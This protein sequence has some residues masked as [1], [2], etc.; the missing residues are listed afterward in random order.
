MK[1]LPLSARAYIAL[2]I[3]AGIFFTALNYSI[4]P[5]H[6]TYEL[7]FFLALTAVAGI[8]K[9]SLPFFGTLSIAYIFVFTT[10]LV[11]GVTESILASIVSS[12]MASLFN[13]R[14]RNP[15]YR[16]L[17]NI[18]AT[19]LTSAGA[20]NIFIIMR[21]TPGTISIPRDLI[22]VFSY[23]FAFY[24]IN[25]FLVSAAISLSGSG[26]IITIWR[27]NYLWTAINYFIAGSSIALLL[28]H[29]MLS[30]NVYLFML[31]LPIIYISYY[32]FKIYL[33]KLEKDKKHSKELADLYLSIIEALAFAIDAKDQTTERH[34]RRVQNLALGIA[35]EMKMEKNEFEALKA[36][37]LLHDIGKIAVPEYIL[38]KPGKLTPEEFKSM[39]AHSDIGA[40]IL[41]TVKFPYPLGPIVRHHHE[42]YDGSGYPEGLKETEIPLGA[43][44]LAIVD[45]YDAL[46]TDRPYRKA[47]SR[48]E[49]VQYMER[50]AGRLFDPKLVE[51]MLG[52][53]EKFDISY[54]DLEASEEK[55]REEIFP[56]SGSSAAGAEIFQTSEKG[57][58]HHDMTSS[59][60]PYREVFDMYET[61]QSFER[62]LDVD[63]LFLLITSKL[64]KLI[65]FK[66]CILFVTDDQKRILIPRCINGEISPHLKDLKIGFGEKLSG[67]ALLHD[68]PYIGRF[69][70]VPLE[71]DGTRSDL[72]DLFHVKEL[73][74]LKNSLV[75]PL[76]IDGDKIGVLSFYD[77]EENE[78]GAEQ[79][80][81]LK[82]LSKFLAPAIKNTF[83]NSTYRGKVYTDLLTGLPSTDYLFISFEREALRAQESFKKMVAFRLELIDFDE[84]KRNYGMHVRRK[85]I[86]SAARYLK[87]HVRSKD[88]SVRFGFHEFIVLIPSLESKD[89]PVIVKRTKEQLS[90][91]NLN[92]SK[93]AATSMSVK[94]RIGHAIYPDDGETIESLL[95][96]ANDRKEYID[97]EETGD[98]SIPEAH[99]ILIFRQ[100][101]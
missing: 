24:V 57:T 3:S 26:S 33:S 70:R 8:F 41:E 69:H 66:S 75:F 76:S 55:I 63:D 90:R 20:A 88:L 30:F 77:S 79:M 16:V 92:V 61:V 89:I 93:S 48:R 4:F 73:E 14:K 53:L 78:Y 42:K 27:E 82:S 86:I 45:C 100:K 60:F 96:I 22:A 58:D 13:V 35:K 1:T 72:E 98:E 29:L 31:S 47:L 83:L 52:N 39:N 97:N 17:F 19:A 99:N 25:T 6:I 49:V 9:V 5:P 81:I 2:I 37:S 101:S 38:N 43:R 67:W 32:S 11:F 68:Q 34:L 44:I 64:R 28:A 46:T 12:L 36:A 91:M 95:N 87:E 65:H 7:I 59:H 85:I 10:L 40:D 56:H 54:Q 50:E 23:T 80:N 51:I 18:S 62:S 15:L 21:G 94:V 74:H 71:R 84:V